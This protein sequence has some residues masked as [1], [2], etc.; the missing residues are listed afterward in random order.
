MTLNKN[1][2]Y[3]YNSHNGYKYKYA[4]PYGK[5]FFFFCAHDN[6][7]YDSVRLLEKPLANKAMGSK[8][9]QVPLSGYDIKNKMDKKPLHH[10][11][12]HINIPV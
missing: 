7:Y 5:G 8:A 4:N 6:L 9:R 12:R 11:R 10:N 3:H 2:N 1:A